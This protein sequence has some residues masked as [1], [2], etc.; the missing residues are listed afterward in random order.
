MTKIA[1]FLIDEHLI[2]R[3]GLRAALE[4]D[5]AI[6]VAG[7]AADVTTACA[8]MRRVSSDVV[9]LGTVQH[10]CVETI[11]TVR[12][13]HPSLCVVVL[14]SPE[15]PGAILQALRAGAQGLLLRRDT[16]RTVLDAVHAVTAG[17]TFLSAEAS[18]ILMHGYA[19]WRQGDEPTDALGRLSRRER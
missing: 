6:V 8:A 12:L 18:G 3:Q 2:M 16:G 13:S 19:R 11:R 17:G 10:N 7:E 1:V 4:P 14:T 15:E 9:I 5:P